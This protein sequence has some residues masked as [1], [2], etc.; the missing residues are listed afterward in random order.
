MNIPE[1]ATTIPKVVFSLEVTEFLLNT[2][3]IESFLRFL[4]LAAEE[5]NIYNGVPPSKSSM[6]V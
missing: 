4:H 5:I 3:E 1:R 6:K 2:L